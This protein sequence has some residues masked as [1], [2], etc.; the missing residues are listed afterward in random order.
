MEKVCDCCSRQNSRQTF[1]HIKK[2]RYASCKKR[3]KWHWKEGITWQDGRFSP[4]VWFWSAGQ[5]SIRWF[6]RLSCRWKADWA[7]IWS[8]TVFQ[9]TH[10]SWK[11]RHLKGHCSI[12]SF[13]WSFR[14]RSCWHW[15]WSWHRSWITKIFVSRDSG[16][17]VFFFPVRL[18]W[19]PT[20]WFSV[21]CLQMTVL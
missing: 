11:T 21:P 13:I 9:T 12:H 4:L 14:C 15:L 8:S 1:F 18:L 6:R 17:P 7:S 16:E 5:A 2:G 19:Y 20:P 3:E 10:E